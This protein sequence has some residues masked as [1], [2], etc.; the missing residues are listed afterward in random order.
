MARQ[1]CENIQCLMY[2][3]YTHSE[4]QQQQ[5][6]RHGG[7][8]YIC[9]QT[10]V[11]VQDDV[12]SRKLQARYIQEINQILW[13]DQVNSKRQKRERKKYPVWFKSNQRKYESRLLWEAGQSTYLYTHMP[14][15]H[16][17]THSMGS[18]HHW[19]GFWIQCIL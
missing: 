17:N 13:R 9:T 10:C 3:S 7:K 11:Q 16:E 12:I 19:A 15:F 6:R 2:N 18:F 8:I 5:K 4:Q 1:C 14:T